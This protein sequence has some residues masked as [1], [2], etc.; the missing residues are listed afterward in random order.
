MTFRVALLWCLSGVL[1]QGGEIVVTGLTPGT[2]YLR[3]DVAQ[4]GTATATR[5][6][7]IS[8]TPDETPGPPTT[9]GSLSGVAKVSYEAA[10]AVERPDE[11]VL[12]AAI[13]QAVADDLA[14]GRLTR[15]EAI[16]KAPRDADAILVALG[17]AQRWQPWRDNVNAY[18]KANP[19]REDAAAD[20]FAGIAKGLETAA[21]GAGL[22]LD[23]DVIRQL[24][25]AVRDRDYVTVL[26]LVLTLVLGNIGG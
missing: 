11:A 24:V 6:P 1:A 3:L 12:L 7:V 15:A 2:H 17:G 22:T 21:Q 5:L 8:A 14:A 20:T 18:L 13:Y 9:P 19:A 26:V 4:D 25:Q 10:K 16:A 23:P